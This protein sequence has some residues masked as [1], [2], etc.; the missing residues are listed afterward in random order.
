M[1]AI[2]ERF[3]DMGRFDD[4]GKRQD[5]KNMG[6]VGVGVGV[7]G[8]KREIYTALYCLLL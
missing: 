3:A 1:V 7:K 5:Y 2:P 6:G 8:E 4:M